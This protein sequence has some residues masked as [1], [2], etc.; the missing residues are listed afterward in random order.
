[1]VFTVSV[2]HPWQI[3]VFI[4]FKYILLT[5]NFIISIR[6]VLIWC[7]NK[8]KQTTKKTKQ[9]ITKQNK[10]KQN[11][12]KTKNKNKNKNKQTNKKQ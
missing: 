2:M 9:N 6:A 12:N 7:E 11:K 5:P 3:R 10:T 4:Y 8:T 1:M